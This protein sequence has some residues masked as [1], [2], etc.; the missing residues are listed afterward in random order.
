MKRSVFLQLAVVAA[1]L[2]GGFAL[3]AKAHTKGKLVGV[4]NLNEASVAQ[5]TMLPGVG[6]KRA[7]AI[8]E[9]AAAH[10]FKSVEELK[11]IKGIGDSGLEKLKPFITVSE[12]STAKWVKDTATAVG[13]SQPVSGN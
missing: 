12:A 9:Y 1:V 2:A 6:Q 4:V 3:Q 13:T 11:A 8:K 5:L 10:P 7:E